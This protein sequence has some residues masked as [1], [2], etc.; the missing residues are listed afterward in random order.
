M[1]TSSTVDSALEILTLLRDRGPLRTGDLVDVTASSRTSVSRLL[2]TLE[3]RGFVR[4]TDNGFVIGTIM[5][6]FA[7]A[8]APALLAAAKPHLIELSERTGETVLMALRDGQYFVIT[9]QIVARHRLTRIEYSSGPSQL[10]TVAAH[11]RAILAHVATDEYESMSNNHPDPSWL[12]EEMRQV[13]SRGVATSSGELEDGV[14]GAASAV[15][16]GAARPLASIGLIAPTGRAD[17]EQWSEAVPAAAHSITVEISA[18]HV[19][20]GPGARR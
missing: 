11:G 3:A 2:V 5:A 7:G 14:V 12:D 13:R 18:D 9:D 19:T 15:L 17:F 6:S 20:T 1:E 4:R 16:D 10:L 8:V